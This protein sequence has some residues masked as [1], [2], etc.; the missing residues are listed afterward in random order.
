MELP[1]CINRTITDKLVNHEQVLNPTGYRF[2]L[3]D[4]SV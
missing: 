3:I 2:D 1:M 4:L